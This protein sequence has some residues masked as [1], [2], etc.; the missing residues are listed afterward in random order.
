MR[1][2]DRYPRRVVARARKPK[3][4]F[5]ASQIARFC[6][7]DLKTIHNWA[8][9]GQIQHFRTP[10]RHLRFRR[11]HRPRLPS[12]V[13]IPDPRRARRCASA[14]GSTRQW[15]PDQTESS[16]FAEQRIRGRRLPRPARRSPPYRRAT[17][18]RG[19]LGGQSRSSKQR[20]DHSSAQARPP[21]AAHPRGPV[22]KRR[23][24]K[25]SSPRS[26]SLS[27]C[28]RNGPDRLE[29]HTPSLDG[30]PSLAPRS[31]VLATSDDQRHR[32]RHRHRPDAGTGAV[33]QDTRGSA[34][35]KGEARRNAPPSAS[36]AKRAAGRTTGGGGRAV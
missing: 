32:R 3:D 5:T 31:Q 19:R 13:R 16:R 35:P 34:S 11:P 2:L 12:Q 4:L 30:R 23:S 14:C 20:R 7:V 18:R 6:Q 8:D 15:E 36:E 10:G 17:A 9:R 27:P 24:R 26:R 29:G 21:Y 22:R 25:T 1:E 28:Q 33:P